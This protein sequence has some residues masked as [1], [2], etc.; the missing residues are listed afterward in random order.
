MKKRVAYWKGPSKSMSR[1]RLGVGLLTLLVNYCLWSICLLS[2]RS[3]FMTADSVDLSMW[4]ILKYAFASIVAVALVAVMS[5]GMVDQIAYR[6]PKKLR[7]SYPM[8]V[9]YL[10]IFFL[11]FV[12]SLVVMSFL[13][14]VFGT[15]HIVA[16]GEGFWIYVITSYF[17]TEVYGSIR[18]NMGVLHTED[19]GVALRLKQ[20][21]VEVAVLRKRVAELGT[22]VDNHFMLNSLAALCILIRKDAD[23]AESFSTALTC[24]YRY[25]VMNAKRMFVPINE[26]LV[27]LRQY[28]QMME[29]RFPECLKVTFEIDS[30]QGEIPSLALHELVGNAIKHNA[31]SKSRP[32]MVS[33]VS[34]GK[35]ITVTNK[36]SPLA[37]TVESTGVGL[38]LLRQRYESLGLPVTVVDDAEQFSV[39]IPVI[40][41]NQDI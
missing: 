20:R 27:F 8:T 4:F 21:E 14:V 10:V 33:I 16:W 3:F 30:A 15:I 19:L 41:N 24:C 9:N 6:R 22:Q 13:A 37:T 35:F 40:I 38:E 39:T 2:K 28:I 31:F 25:M 36:R 32:L 34:D 26:E 11:T 17:C 1:L 7:Y 12:V 5:V 29:I 23:R 18:Y